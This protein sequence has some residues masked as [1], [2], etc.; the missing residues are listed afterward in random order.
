MAKPVKLSGIIDVYLQMKLSKE[1]SDEL[2]NISPL[3]AGIEEKNIFSVP[4]GYFDELSI[5]LEPV[6][7]NLKMT[8]Y[9]FL[10]DISKI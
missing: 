3:L 5:K 10:K 1:I 9:L 2:N 4:Q 6:F 8:R 7:L